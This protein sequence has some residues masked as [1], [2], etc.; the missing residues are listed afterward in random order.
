M[1]GSGEPEFLH[2]CLFSLSKGWLAGWLR[3]LCV[4]PFSLPGRHKK[5]CK[6]RK[7]GPSQI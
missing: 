6:E 7:Q 4:F 2:T 1:R 5:V 3:R